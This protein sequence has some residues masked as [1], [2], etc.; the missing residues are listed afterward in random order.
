[1]FQMT[2]WRALG[3]ASDVRGVLAF[4]RAAGLGLVLLLIAL[5]LVLALALVLVALLSRVRPVSFSRMHSLLA[6]GAAGACV[7]GSRRSPLLLAA[8]AATDDGADAD[9]NGA[10][11]SVG[12]GRNIISFMALKY[13]ATTTCSGVWG[14]SWRW[15]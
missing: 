1:M 15:S 10:G 9:N 5:V 4:V 8:G 12:A 3:F 11:G 2:S 7:G 6:A 13:L 14:G